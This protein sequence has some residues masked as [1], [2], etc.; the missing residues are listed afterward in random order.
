MAKRFFDIILALSL[1]VPATLLVACAAIWIR[2]ESS[3]PA[4]FRQVR[5]GKDQ[6]QFRMFKLRTMQTGTGDRASHEIST[7]QITK[8]GKWL[9]R[10]KID[11]LPQI[12]SVLIGDMSFVGPRPC[13]P[14][15]SELIDA[16]ESLGVFSVSPGIT[17]PAQI[18]GIDM[19]TPHKLA[20]IDADYVNEQ[21]F[22]RDLA[23]IWATAFGKGR[24]DAAT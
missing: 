4:I 19:S 1:L 7:S 11:E 20:H 16:R 3:G 14:I 17:G 10:I 22:G 6:K 15:Q 21:S 23:Y 24:G 9:R 2:V 8:A 13:L 18:A 5:V 12:W